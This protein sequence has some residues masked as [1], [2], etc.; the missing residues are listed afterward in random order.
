VIPQGEL[1]AKIEGLERQVDELKT[2]IG[3]GCAR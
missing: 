3:S 2:V 1:L